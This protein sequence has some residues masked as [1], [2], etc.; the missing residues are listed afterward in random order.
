M[1]M[2]NVLP[3]LQ[4]Y[5]LQFLGGVLVL[6]IGFVVVK[7]I[8]KSVSTLMD[9]RE[10][11]ASLRSFL[12]SMLSFGLK[13]MV[14]LTALSVAGVQVTS[15]IA[16]LGAA[17]LAIGL[18]LQGSLSNFAGGVM[19]LLF[20]PFKVGDYIEG[21]GQAGTVKDIQ[22]FHTVLTPLDN[23]TV[24]IPNGNFYNGPVV[25]FSTQPLRRLVLNYGIAYGDDADKAKEVLLG[26][27]SQDERVLHEPNE[28]F[29]A[30]AGLGDSSVDF[31]L[32]VWV[33]GSDYWP[34][35]FDMNDRVY[36]TFAQQGLNI[37]FPQMDVHLHQVG[38][39]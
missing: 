19:I 5:A 27:I 17:G 3:M 7:I 12:S 18:A 20:K 39:S 14:V 36:K 22:L 33:K 29:V 16:V 2:K 15:F 13:A 10:M 28:P 37:P 8:V 25:N 9:K 35:L 32:R 21:Q 11:D 23:R 30:M 38:Q 31:T 1:D 24:I 4:Q 26:L 6:V 34:L